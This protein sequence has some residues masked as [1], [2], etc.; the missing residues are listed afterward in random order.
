MN[1]FSRLLEAA[2]R[3][4]VFLSYQH[5][6]DQW[7]YNEFVRVMSLYYEAVQDNSLSRAIDS[8]DPTYVMRR[9]RENHIT[10]TSSTIVLCGAGT[11]GRKYVDWEIKA[12]LDKQHGLIGVRL[13]TNPAGYVPQRFLD[14]W[15]SGFAAWTSW[16]E[17]LASPSDFRAIVNAARAR[18]T[19]LIAPARQ[20]KRRNS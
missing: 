12:T 17:L 4:R 16:E 15:E 8:D 1:P 10:G 2:A 18:S 14:N 5:A 20:L 13:P 9:I 3:P 6:L 19:A 7:Y 11:P